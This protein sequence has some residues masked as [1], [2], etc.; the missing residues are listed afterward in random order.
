MPKMPSRPG[1]PASKKPE[2]V[3]TQH[4]HEEALR[5]YELARS[6]LG[7]LPSRRSLN[8]VTMDPDSH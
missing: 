1:P 7:D 3:E 6:A 2:N 5:W 8:G 4:Q